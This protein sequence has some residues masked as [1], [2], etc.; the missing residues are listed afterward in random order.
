MSIGSDR[1]LKVVL[2]S[3][4]VDSSERIFADELIAVQ[5]IKT[6][7]SLIKDAIQS[8]GGNLVKSLGDGVLATFDAPTQALEF[9]QDAVEQLVGQRGGHSLQHRFGIHV[10]EIY[11]NGDDI[12]GQGVHLASRLQTIAPPNGVAFLQSTYEMVDSEFRQRARSMGLVPLAGLPAPVMCYS[13]A[14]KQL[15]SDR[16]VAPRDGNTIENV[17]AGSPYHLER[18]LGRSPGS[19]T[20]LVKDPNRDRH[21]VLKLFPG[22][23]EQLAAME[24]E[25]ACLDRLRHPRIPRSLD[26]F[27]RAGQYCLLQEW[28]PGPSL[29]GSFDYL[30]KKQRLS[31]LL[32]QVLEV[33]EVT[34]SAG[35]LHGDLHPANL[36]PD[37]DSGQLFVVDFS[38]IKSRAGSSSFILP[39]P[40][41]FPS[42]ET[43]QAQAAG[44][45]SRSFFSP[46][47]LIRFGRIWAGVDL[48][49]LGVTALALYSGRPPGEL[50]DQDIGGWNCGDLDPEVMAWLSPLLEESPGRRIHS[51]AD[52]LQRLDRPQSA[53]IEPAHPPQQV[54]IEAADSAQQGVIEKS[55]LV[56]A[57]ARTYGPVVQLLLDSWPSVIPFSR[58]AT[59]R[60]KLEDCGMRAE[61]IEP[62]LAAASIRP[63]PAPT[64][65]TATVSA[66]SVAGVCEREREI[67]LSV[68]R[69]SIGPVADLLLTPELI[70][71]LMLGDQT[72]SATLSGNHLQDEAIQELLEVA[73]QLRERQAPVP[74][75]WPRVPQL[76]SLTSM[77]RSLL[78]LKWSHQEDPTMPS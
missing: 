43:E 61:D 35:I 26:G 50:Y 48:Y 68:L 29:D 32:R 57:L 12:I 67:L 5:H 54:V 27:I 15:L 14:E 55:R 9:V 6:D 64:A 3:D 52:A 28:I 38:L 58:E 53:L 63:V 8:H 17:L 45:T 22:D 59:L 49:G 71:K 25:A 44:V 75:P 13:I 16:A 39:T 23:R 37:A 60:T 31:E 42:G 4:V 19:R 74:T 56:A 24:L 72:V 73:R 2:F 70:A 41:S 30:R 10:G 21:A 78:K 66:E 36:I 47:E 76:K 1:Q 62:A 33:L 18:S 69:R 77:G 65:P 34:H 40:E 11:A 46:P 7:L 51:A 20:Y